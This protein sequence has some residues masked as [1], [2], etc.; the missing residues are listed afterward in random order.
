MAYIKRTKIFG[1]EI[2]FVFKHKFN[3]T[4]TLLNTYT[5]KDWKLGMFAKQSKAVGRKPNDLSKI[6]IGASKNLIK[7]FMIGFDL[8]II[9]FWFT[10]NR[11]E[12]FRMEIE[13]GD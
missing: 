12:I 8:L 11:G 9:K 2:T 4:K 1:I 5:W 13:D 6:K 7:Q 3:K 10:F